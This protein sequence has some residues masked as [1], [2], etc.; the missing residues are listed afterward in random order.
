MLNFGGSD[1][2]SHVSPR[3][4]SRSE[5]DRTSGSASRS[6]K[7]KISMTKTIAIAPDN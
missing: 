6:R 4:I 5:A 2:G 1:V 7:A 3:R